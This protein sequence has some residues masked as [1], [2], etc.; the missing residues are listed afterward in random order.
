MAKEKIIGIDLGTTNSVV[1]I[2]E[3]KTPRVLENPNGKRTTPSVVS[4]KNDDIIV[5]EVAKRQLET[6]IN[7]IASIKRKMGTSETVK[8]NDKEY[9]PEEISAMIL[10]YLKDY[11]EKKIGSKIKKAVITVPA[12]FNNAQ[13]EATK[14]AG[15]IAGLSV[16]RIINEPTAAAL[17][18]GLDKT[19][20]EQKILVYDLGGG[21][22]DVS[23]LELANGTFEVLSTSGDNFLGGD[24]WDNEIVKW[25]IGK[26]KLEHKYDVSK[27]KMAM[28]RLKEEAEK[29]KINLST[30]ST[31]SINLPF[32]AVTDSGPI[33]VEVELKRS[34]FEKMTQHLVE[35][36]RKPVRDALKEAKLKS[37]D[38]HEVLLVG[39]STR[40]PAVQEML[41]HELN[42]KPNHSINPD[43]VVAIG[44]AIQGAVL[45][46]DIND[47]LLLDVTPLTLGIETQGGIATPLIQRNTTIPTT[48][49]QIFSTAADNQSEV[50][51]NVV[52]GERQMAADNKSLGQFNLGGIEK[53][54]RGTPQIEVSF[55]IDVNGIIK[56]SATDKKTNKIQTITIENSTSLTEE[57]I[58]KMIDD[59]EKNKEA[60]AKKKEKI[61][62]TVRAETL[63]NQ[64]EK[65]IKDQGDKID[66][67]EKEQT[68][69]EI[70]NIKDLILQ[71]KIDELKIK[72]DQIEEVAKAFAQK[73]ASKET[74]KNEQNEDGSIDAEIKEEDPKA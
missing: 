42:K 40:I 15:R 13:R 45:S 53:A 11:A 72:L 31:T 71:D 30:T 3:D 5:G 67:K 37:E 21:T 56:V 61:D 32:L 16:E 33:N 60:D 62:V 57:E 1:A 12:Y 25:L 28:A 17:A 54:P 20:K 51:I 24:D 27:D 14:T 48:K 69:K 26:I 70:T 18:F 44:A 73:A 64:L 52:Q 55:S 46:G 50:T 19:D 29:A 4:F 47:V 63:I 2:L 35:R 66:P 6:N 43:E 10:S 22:F 36:T 7:T 34:D 38:L 23:V 41:Q 65:T 58:K 49:S 59:A 39:G 68:E 8:I 74:S 9:K